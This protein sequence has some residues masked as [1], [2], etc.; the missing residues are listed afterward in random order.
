MRTRLNNPEVEA[1]LTKAVRNA[2]REYFE[3][4]TEAAKRVVESVLLNRD[5]RV[6]AKAAR[7][8]QRKTRK[9]E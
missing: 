9:D 1:V 5:A 3:A 4:N 6:A 7:Q 2:V 8:Q